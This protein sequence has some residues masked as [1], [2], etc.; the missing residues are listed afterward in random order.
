MNNKKHILHFHIAKG[1]HQYVASG[2]ELPVVTQGPTLDELSKNIKEAVD[3]HLE[4]ENLDELGISER[5][6]VLVDFELPA[7]QYA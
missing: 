5:P 4:G 7:S 1:E 6:S 2:V 3:L